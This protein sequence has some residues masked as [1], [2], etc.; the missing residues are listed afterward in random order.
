M[1]LFCPEDIAIAIATVYLTEFSLAISICDHNCNDPCQQYQIK[2]ILMDI[3]YSAYRDSH[4][5][6]H[7]NWS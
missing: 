5:S 4:M 7:R 3:P 1:C 6:I 2:I